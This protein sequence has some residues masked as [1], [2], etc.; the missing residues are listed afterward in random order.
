MSLGL[1]SILVINL[2]IIRIDYYLRSDKSCLNSSGGAGLWERLYS[3]A[4]FMMAF[5]VS[6]RTNF[7][8]I[9]HT[10]SCTGPQFATDS[11]TFMI[12][13]VETRLDSFPSLHM[14]ILQVRF[15]CVGSVGATCIR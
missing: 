4:Y 1:D 8:N 11:V 15:P 10:N 13:N 12:V 9:V 7:K 2:C 3:F 14:A 5:L 6:D